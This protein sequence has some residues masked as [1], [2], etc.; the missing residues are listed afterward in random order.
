MVGDDRQSRCL[1]EGS[2]PRRGGGWRVFHR[3]DGHFQKRSTRPHITCAHY[4]RACYDRPT[5]T[6][7]ED[8]SRRGIDAC[9]TCD[10]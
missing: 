9:D 6:R 8:P 10:T 7:R 3:R 2:E 5:H 1:E 4:L